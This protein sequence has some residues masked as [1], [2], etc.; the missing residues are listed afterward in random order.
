MLTLNRFRLF[1]L[2]LILSLLLGGCA[3]KESTP[4]LVWPPPPDEPRLEFVGNFYSE[5]SFEKSSKQKMMSDFLG[6]RGQATFATPFGI[7]SDGKGIVYISDIHL[8]NVRIYDFN[9][10]TVDFLTKNS[11]MGTP[12]GLAL[13]QA[14]NL[15]IADA[16]KGQIFVFG[17]DRLPRHTISH[18]EELGK[19]SY[20]AVDDKLG[21]LYVSDGLKHKIIVFSLTGEFLYSFGGHGNDPGYFFSPQGIALGPDGNL[22]VADMFNARV[23]IVTPEGQFVRMFGVRGDQPGQ[24]ENPKDLAFDSEGNLHVLEGRRSDLMSFTPD[25]K[26]LLVTGGGRPTGGAFGFGSPRGIAIDANDRIHI[27]EA[28]NRRFTIWQYMSKAYL[29]RQ[30]YTAEDRQA[31]IDY[32]NKLAKEREKAAK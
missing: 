5:E 28:T 29:A 18:K 10:K 20:L 14:G 11:R 27:T 19:P 25:G 9:K 30:P 31:L 2:L 8:H 24:F 21:R 6:V 12:A 4:R 22:Y 13:D 7:A 16:G 32:T 17:P 3:A 15:Y 26:I 23:Q 1:L